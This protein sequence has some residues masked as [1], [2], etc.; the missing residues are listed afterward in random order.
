MNE[1]LKLF[2]RV[3][4][5][6]VDHTEQIGEAADIAR[7]LVHRGSAPCLSKDW[8][9]RPIRVEVSDPVKIYISYRFALF[10]FLFLF[11]AYRPLKSL[12]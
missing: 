5:D 12:I 1:Y 6:N 9:L 7:T 3:K 10:V 2:D 11:K 8:R 4:N